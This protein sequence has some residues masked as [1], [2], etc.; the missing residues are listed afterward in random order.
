MTHSTSFILI[1][2]G[3]TLA[4]CQHPENYRWAGQ[5][6]YVR[7]ERVT[8][9]LDEVARDTR[10]DWSRP[11]V[12]VYAFA[13]PPKDAP[14]PVGIKDFSDHG[15]AALIL[16]MAQ[17]GAKPDQIRAAL[18]KPI[19][20]DANT[21]S[22]SASSR[23]SFSF[24]RTLVATVS[25]GLMARPGDRLMWTWIL[26]KPLN[27]E[28]A[29]YTILAT[30]ND[31]L[32]IE[33]VQNQTTTTLRGEITASLPGPAKVEPS[34]SGEVANQYTTSAD[35]NQQYVRNGVD[36]QPRFLRIY[37]ESERNLD[38][39][40]NTLIKLSLVAKPDT[41]YGKY[42]PPQK[43]LRATNPKLF[44][45]GKLLAPMEAALD[46]SSVTLPFR[47]DLLAEVRLIY[48]MRKID[49]NERSYVEGEQRVTIE[50]DASEWRKQV[51]MKADEVAP[52]SWE[53]YDGS[54]QIYGTTVNNERLPLIF[55]N[56][57]AA[58]D[59]ASW[60]MAERAT[61]I[62]KTPLQLTAGGEPFPKRYPLLI[63]RRVP[64]KDN[65]QAI[66]EALG[67]KDSSASGR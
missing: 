7:S 8:A 49:S 43:V 64:D 24:D 33:K 41:L 36:V 60:M 66:C 27:F 29:G 17:K 12:D 16:A 22:N 46:V 15:Q 55:T 11:Q 54:R 20:D 25:K 13:T 58:R 59:M 37:R 2:A 44:K 57:D 67:F 56:Y 1:V 42:Q 28:F 47:C 30:D 53:I 9:A 52:P 14:A 50:Q 19:T 51:I 65:Q 18:A 3:V 26:V 35:I 48:Q 21:S 61:R 10:I 40:G 5:A 6:A 23:D 34:A 62:G 39:A 38:V 45:E 4:G 63:A 32:T 31:T